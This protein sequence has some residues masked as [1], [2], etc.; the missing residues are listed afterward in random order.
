MD[1][2]VSQILA[3]MDQLSEST[4]TYDGNIGTTKVESKDVYV[5]G[6]TNRPDLLEPA[7]LRPGRFDRKIY[8]S[9]CSDVASKEAILKAAT[10][11]FILSAD[12]SLEDVANSLP[13][14]MSGADVT[15]VCRTAYSSALERMLKQIGRAAMI[16]EKRV[17]PSNDEEYEDQREEEFDVDLDDPD[18]CNVISSYIDSLPAEDI[19][20]QVNTEDFLSAAANTKPSITMTELHEYEKLEKAFDDRVAGT[21]TVGN[22]IVETEIVWTESGIAQIERRKGERREDNNTSPVDM[23]YSVMGLID[24]EDENC[25]PLVSTVHANGSANDH[26]DSSHMSESLLHRPS[27]S[28]S[29][30]NINQQE[31]VFR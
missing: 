16:E 5:I 21:E 4:T 7:L 29:R 10:R 20:V 13:E 12:V 15:A 26:V 6:A 17:G 30:R 24:G 3:E 22:K 28:I 25:D 27:S 14:L 31:Q 18:V 23:V 11:K 8:I 9:L 19:L 1:R 2:V